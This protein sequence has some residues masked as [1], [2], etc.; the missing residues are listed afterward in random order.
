MNSSNFK[1]H[2][3]VLLKE[4]L[5]YLRPQPKQTYLD[6]T[7]GGGG[8]AQAI[9]A[10]V[11]LTNLVLVDLDPTAITNLKPQFIG[12][13]FYNDNFANRV[14]KLHKQARTF[15]M[16]LADLGISQL[17]LDSERGF[18]FRSDYRLDMRFNP[19]QG[20]SLQDLLEQASLDQLSNVL[21]DYGQER[22]ALA[23]AQAI[24]HKKPQTSRQ[25]SSLVA[26]IKI[27][28]KHQTIHPATQT[29]MALRIW[30]NQEL[31]SLEIFLQIAPEL[32]KKGGRLAIISFHSLEDRLVKNSFRDWTEGAYTDYFLPFKKPISASSEVLAT[33]Q[34]ARSAK[35]RLLQRY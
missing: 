23:I 32:L 31:K 16:I 4:V 9:A 14:Q 2:K 7:A 17:Q 15:D 6:A 5:T 12:A 26:K 25:L 21:R 10:I 28:L 3:P 22:Q 33:H 29:F 35:L 13:T 1:P 30:V 18:S 19:N 8:H 20:L 34:Q 27:P 11:G 24:K